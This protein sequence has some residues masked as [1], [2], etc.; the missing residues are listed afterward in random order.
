MAWWKGTL[1]LLS[2]R[3][4]YQREVEWAV[5]DGG[6]PASSKPQR[7]PQ[8]AGVG[9]P[10]GSATLISPGGAGLSGVTW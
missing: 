3:L 10:R 5:W 7:S 6:Q 2:S 1:S 8:T 9:T 4:T